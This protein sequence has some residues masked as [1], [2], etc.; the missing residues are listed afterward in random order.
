MDFKI[1]DMTDK[2]LIEK[3]TEV[4]QKIAEI[5]DKLKKEQRKIT[6]EERDEVLE[7]RTLAKQI[8]EE[9]KN[10]KYEEGNSSTEGKQP[11]PHSRSLF[12]PNSEYQRIVWPIYKSAFWAI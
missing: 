7:Y 2:S 6:A 4:A 10:R 3:Q 12:Q 5:D 1:S 8:T 9:L 11:Q